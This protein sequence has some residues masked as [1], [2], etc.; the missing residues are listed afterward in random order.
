MPTYKFKDTNTGEEIEKFM[1]ISA[2]EQF[3]QDNPH[4]ESMIAGCPHDWRS[5]EHGRNQARF[6]LQ[7]RAATNS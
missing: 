1:S 6:R 4:L 7:T 2:R 3:I 5:C